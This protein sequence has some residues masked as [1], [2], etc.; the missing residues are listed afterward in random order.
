MEINWPVLI[1]TGVVLASLLL[2]LVKRN[3]RDKKILERKLNED[4][5]KSKD[6]E[7]DIEIEDTKSV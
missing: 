3:R 6:E 1:I 4:F 7:G 2:F 5:K